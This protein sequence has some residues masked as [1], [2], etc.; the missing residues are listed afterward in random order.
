MITRSTINKKTLVITVSRNVIY[1]NIVENNITQ[2]YRTVSQE[3]V[4]KVT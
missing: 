4:C 2:C 3:Y 1:N